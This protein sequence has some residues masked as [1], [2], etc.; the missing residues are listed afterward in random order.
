MLFESSTESCIITLSLKLNNKTQVI[1]FVLFCRVSISAG[2]IAPAIATASI[3]KAQ[4]L[5]LEIMQMT[6]PQARAMVCA[7]NVITFK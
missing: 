2:K 6:F 5:W 3:V 7:S 4:V 1:L